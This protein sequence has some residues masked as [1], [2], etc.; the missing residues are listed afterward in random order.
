MVQG[1][2][3]CSSTAGGKGSIPGLGTKI[4]PVKWHS[5]I[6]RE[7]EREKLNGGSQESLLEKQ[8]ATHSSILAR[9]IP[10]TRNLV[11]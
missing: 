1:L 7:R 5:Q 2:R 10:W 3:L 11:A 8:M 4:P 9:R 6:E